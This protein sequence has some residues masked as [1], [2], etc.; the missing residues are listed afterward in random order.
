MRAEI[1][2]AEVNKIIW[3]YKLEEMYVHIIFFQG[4]REDREWK[5]K[6]KSGKHIF[7]IWNLSLFL[8]E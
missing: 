1:R 5:L 4:L 2:L 8:D 7:E 6:E 3:D